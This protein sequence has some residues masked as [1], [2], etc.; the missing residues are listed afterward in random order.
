MLSEQQKARRQIGLVAVRA[1][2]VA[3]SACLLA[4]IFTSQPAA[5]THLQAPCHNPTC[6]VGQITVDNVIALHRLGLPVPVYT[7]YPL[8]AP[9]L[10]GG[11]LFLVSFVIFWRRSDQWFP[12]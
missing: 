8:L 3:I 12:F 5:Y 4:L 6:D 7:L 9:L 11:I 1:V 10:T 2:W